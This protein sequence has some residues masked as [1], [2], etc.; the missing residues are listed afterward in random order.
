MPSLA[1]KYRPKTFKQVKGNE[2]LISII[3]RILKKKMQPQTYILQGTR[4]CG[5]TTLARIMATKLG[6][7][8]RDLKE[9]NI[10]DMRG[11]DTARQ[12]IENIGYMPMESSNKVIILNEVHQA[13]KDFQNAMLEKLEEPPDGVYF[14]LCTTE[15][16]KLLD[17]VR[18]RCA[19]SKYYVKPLT[20]RSLQSIVEHVLDC[21]G[22]EWNVRQINRLVRI[23][24]GI[25]REALILLDG[26]IGLK[27]K[28]LS[29]AL[30]K[31]EKQTQ[32]LPIELA[33]ALNI[34][35]QWKEVARILNQLEGEDAEGVRRLVLA[36]MRKVLLNNPSGRAAFTVE[37]FED[38]F[39][40]SGMAG[41]ALACYK[42]VNFS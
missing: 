34:G 29:K 27:G 41:L 16:Q 1:D 7:K 11:I 30:E 42:A 23:A 22:V 15:P 25:P 4:G 10:S 18:S 8:G 21:E 32:E 37:C 36:Y 13:T 26:L 9:L 39:Y 17:T 35:Q 2:Q 3:R 33:R 14:I 38:N 40:D 31:I 28:K 6:A 20:R 19:L 5:K 24:D 12:L